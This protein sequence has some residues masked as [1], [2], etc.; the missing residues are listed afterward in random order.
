M[1]RTS[2][3]GLALTAALFASAAYAVPHGPPGKGRVLV[4]RLEGPV[5]PVTAQA[6][7]IA[8]GRA[9]ARGYEVAVGAQ[10]E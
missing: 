8:V 5:S 10:G 9:E 6:L 7:K 1:R 3:V 2:V 4:M